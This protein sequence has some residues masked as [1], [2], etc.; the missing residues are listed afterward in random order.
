MGEYYKFVNKTRKEE[1]QIS[2]PFNFG[3]PYGKSLENYESKEVA[4]MFSFVIKHNDNWTEEDDVT[5]IGDYGA[6]I[7]YKDIKASG[8]YR[9]EKYEPKKVPP[10]KL[11]NMQEIER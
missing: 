2:L 3:L 10:K 1:S 8:E 9:W 6:I 7:Q 4:A 5:A 11:E